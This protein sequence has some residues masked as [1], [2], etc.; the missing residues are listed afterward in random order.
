MY[1][2]SFCLNLFLTFTS[3]LYLV[4]CFVTCT[5]TFHQHYPSYFYRVSFIVTVV[6]S[7]ISLKTPLKCLNLCFPFCDLR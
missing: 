7:V 3:L 6:E 4:V 2:L 1:L 5:L